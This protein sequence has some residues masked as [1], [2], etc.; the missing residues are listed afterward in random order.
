MQ[1]EE[2][3]KAFGGRRELAKASQWGMWL[4][5]RWWTE[6]KDKST[7]TA[8]ALYTGL[9]TA[10]LLN[11]DGSVKNVRRPEDP[12]NSYVAEHVEFLEALGRLG[13][14]NV[15]ANGVDRN[16]LEILRMSLQVSAWRLAVARAVLT[17]LAGQVV[18]EPL[19]QEGVLA[20]VATEEV[21]VGRYL[22]YGARRETAGAIAPRAEFYDVITACHMTAQVDAVLLF[23]KLPWLLDPLKELGCLAARLKPGGYVYVVEPD[24]AASPAY[25]AAL[26][27]LGAARAVPAGQV[28]MWLSAAG[29]RLQSRPTS[30]PPYYMS[31]W[32]KPAK[33][34][35]SP[36][37]RW[38]E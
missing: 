15:D 5:A 37:D 6:K 30:F 27:A 2:L 38:M 25:S 13:L 23:E 29:L 11:A 1:L 24:A 36:S 10:G 33:P 17:Q 4:G 28:E 35:L 21:G 9:A 26:V 20:H 32:R 34:S 16:S 31:V 7:R 14:D 12:V 3:A 8:K 18:L 19:V 22:G